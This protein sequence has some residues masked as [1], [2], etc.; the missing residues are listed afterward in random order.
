MG[1]KFQLVDLMVLVLLFAGLFTWYRILAQHG[2]GVRLYAFVRLGSLIWV[3]LGY[4]CPALLVGSLTLTW[5]W[6]RPPRA[7]WRK[8]IVQPGFSACFL[9]SVW[10][11]VR[12]VLFVASEGLGRLP[13]DHGFDARIHFSTW[14]HRW[15]LTSAYLFE[16]CGLIVLGGWS[17]LGMAG[18]WRPLA[19]VADRLGRMIGAAWIL[20]WWVLLVSD[21]QEKEWG[22]AHDAKA[23]GSCR[24]V[25]AGSGGDRWCGLALLDLS[26]L[27]QAAGHESWRL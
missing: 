26:C 21:Y 15:L 8:L 5:F 3:P 13:I 25:C 7:C 6:L 9:V 14:Q 27:P 11:L 17:L 19:T 10:F 4:H 1:R 12:V 2:V 24:S 16:A 22:H 20:G 18:L 23:D